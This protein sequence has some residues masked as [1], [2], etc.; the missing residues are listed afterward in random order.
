M[1]RTITRRL[2]C[3]ARFHKASALLFWNTF[4]LFLSLNIVLFLLLEIRDYFYK[5]KNP[6]QSNPVSS[7][8]ERSLQELYPDL[9]EK[10]INIL[11]NETWLRPYKYE[12]FTGF[13]ERPYTG[14]YVNVNENGFRYTKHQG[15]WPPDPSSFNVFLFGGSTAFGYGLPDEQT[16]ASSLQQ[17]L[18]EDV[19]RGVRVYNFGRGYYYSTQERIL[20]EQLLSSGF[21]PDMAVFV[22]GMNDFT[23]PK[24]EPFFTER[25]ERLLEVQPQER[26]PSP[27]RKLPVYRAALWFKH[28]TLRVLGSEDS[29][30]EKSVPASVSQESDFNQPAVIMNVIERYTRNKKMI[31]AVAA[32][33]GV[34]SVFVWQPAPT[35]KYDLKYHL[36][37]QNNQRRGFFK[38]TYSK[39]GYP[40][41]A[42]LAKRNLWGE[43]F[44]WCADI[45]DGV[46]EPLYVDMLHYTHKLTKGL[47]SCISH[48][49][50]E[51]GLLPVE[52]R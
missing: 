46:K 44:L 24:D 15:P 5:R 14:K 43:N 1:S 4:I 40:H 37:Y 27:L 49:M 26:P 11:L 20:F 31:E 13:K 35:Y 52:K 25:F 17:I 18:T 42:E 6:N 51:K 50:K 10:E 9:D 22:D 19:G 7:R 39:F 48:L 23:Y 8:Y 16:L 12:P 30:A 45:Q 33:N 34:T 28:K 41:V 3:V 32:A 38:H 29:M 47:A 2:R 21:L 36:F